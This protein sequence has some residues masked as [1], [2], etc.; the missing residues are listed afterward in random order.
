LIPGALHYLA[1]R[2]RKTKIPSA[3]VGAIDRIPRGANLEQK[4]ESQL[5]VEAVAWEVR[6]SGRPDVFILR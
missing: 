4:Q 5:E 1:R 2:I 3:I 6:T